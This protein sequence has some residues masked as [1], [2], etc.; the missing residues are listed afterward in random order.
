MRATWRHAPRFAFAVT[1]AC[2]V[3]LGCQ[4]IV[5]DDAPSFRCASLAED[6]CPSGQTCDLSIGRC[7][8][9]TPIEDAGPV[10]EDGGAAGD[11]TSDGPSGPLPIGAACR[12]DGDCASDLCGTSNV[13]TAV[14][15]GPSGPVCTKSCCTSAECPSGFVCFGAGTGG[16]YCVAAA[17]ASRSET[18][19]ASAGATCTAS[20]DCRSG[21]CQDGRCIDTCC[22]AADCASGTTCRLLV[23]TVP[24]P[25]REDWAC[26][27]PVTPSDAGVGDGC[28]LVGGP[29]C[30]NNACFGSGASAA[31]RPP[32]CGTDSCTAAGYPN[33]RCRY[34]T[35]ITGDSVKICFASGAGAA[36]GAACTNDGECSSGYCDLELKK[37]AA[38]CC[39]DADC[40]NGG[41][42][43]PAAAG[44]P[45]LRCVERP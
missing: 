44:P 34:G 23:V 25:D 2:V 36:N 28:N 9:P 20:R 7:V 31:C 15:T 5:G 24:A 21:N 37:C 12:L 38:T 13:L 29:V 10:E 32:C 11:A 22:R 26:A 40:A 41:V 4:V 16:N 27:P 30:S 3:A 6:A 18:G 42:C 33:G 17:A 43:R 1:I 39:V 14:V 8:Q 45:R 35:S 19:G